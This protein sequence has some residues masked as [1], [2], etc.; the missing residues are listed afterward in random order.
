MFRLGLVGGGRMGQTHMRALELSTEVQV[1][2]VAEPHQP[3]ASSLQNL[4]LRTF[5]TVG[6]MLDAGRID[7][8]LIA[9]PSNQHLSLIQ[10]IGSAGLPI[11][12][13]KPCGLAAAEAVAAGEAVKRLGIPL[14]IGYWR[15]FVPGLQAMRKAIQQGDL[16]SV[17]LLACTQWDHRP[18]P[19]RFRQSS[20]GIFTDMG[21]HEIDQVRWLTGQEISSVSVSAF[22]TTRDPYVNGD[23]D[24]AQA[25]LTLT[26]GT[27]ATISLGRYFP[28]GD[29]VSA[30]VFGTADHRR[31]NVL[32]PAEGERPQLEALRRQDEAFARWA[33]GGPPEGASIA[34]AIAALEVAEQ[35]TAYLPSRLAQMQ[36]N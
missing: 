24:S 29:F 3:T 11:L 10:T 31:T 32:E 34:D 20:G 28:D 9:A 21:V 5:A 22:P 7:G 12:C 1:Q 4:G 17:H 35:L 33:V 30:E 14:Q 6:D 18:P 25:L 16:G 36:S 15:R 26:E 13:E 2:A 23:V 19:A 8:V 27:A